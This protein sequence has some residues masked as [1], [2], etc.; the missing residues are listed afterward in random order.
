MEKGLYLVISGPSGVGKDTVAQRLGGW[1]SVSATSRKIR[2]GEV[3]GINYFYH[4]REEMEELIARG[5]LLEYTVYNGEY[6]GTPLQPVREH[7]AQG[8]LVIFVIEVEGAANVKKAFPEAVTVFLMP[9]SM[10]ELRAR[11]VNRK[12]ETSEQVEKRMR[13]AVREI[14]IGKNEYDYVVVN[15]EI[16]QAV[17]EIRK[18]VD[19]EIKR[20]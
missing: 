13:T 9:P 3:E 4:S 14:E 2:E 11:L 1:I 20:R 12:T 16:D 6:Y 19:E 10:D 8:E 5:A 18:I 17:E 7:F 15:D